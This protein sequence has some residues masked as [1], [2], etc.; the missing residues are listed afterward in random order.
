MSEAHQAGVR[1][2]NQHS[3]LLVL[4]TKQWSLFDS[5]EVPKAA[6][7]WLR[8]RLIIVTWYGAFSSI[9]HGRNQGN[10][11]RKCGNISAGIINHTSRKA[12]SGRSSNMPY[13]GGKANSASGLEMA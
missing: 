1:E 7:A 2:R 9:N 4:G 12:G 8:H 3:C 5:A 13:H 11:E 10:E 6:S